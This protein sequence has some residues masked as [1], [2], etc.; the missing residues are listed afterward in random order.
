MASRQPWIAS[1][2]VSIYHW[3]EVEKDHVQLQGLERRGAPPSELGG[4]HAPPP[5]F[6]I[7]NFTV[8]TP[9]LSNALT[10]PTHLQI[11]GAALAREGVFVVGGGGC[12]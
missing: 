8:L 7:C 3:A 12:W 4:G 1:T 2:T 11:R 6:K 9:L 5:F 10:P